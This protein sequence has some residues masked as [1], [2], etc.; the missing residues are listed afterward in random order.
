MSRH[1]VHHYKHS[2]A[3]RKA[4]LKAKLKKGT[5]RLVK[6]VK[7]GMI[8]ETLDGDYRISNRGNLIRKE[9]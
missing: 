3:K 6:L 8:I 7:Y 1:F 2:H 9:E 5:A 4:Q